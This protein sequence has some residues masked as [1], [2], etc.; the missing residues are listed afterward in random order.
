MSSLLVEEVRSGHELDVGKL[1]VFLAKTVPGLRLPLTLK[2][3][4]VGQSNPTY[5]VTDHEGQKYVLRKKPAGQLLSK[6]AHAVER[7]FRILQALGQHTQVPVPRVHVLCEDLNVVGTPF[8]LMEFLDGRILPDVRLPEIKAEERRQYWEALVDV[9]AL[10]H[11]VDYRRVGLGEGFGKSSGYYERQVKSLRRIS[12]AQAMAIGRNGDAADGKLPGIDR[13]LRWL[14]SRGCPDETTIVHGDFKMDNVVWHATEIRV[15]GILDWELS[16]LGNPRSDLANMLQPL[17]VPYT[18]TTGGLA[19]FSGLKGA[20][21]SEC[22]PNENML[23]A[24]YRQAMDHQQQ[25]QQQSPVLLEGW[26]YAKVFA[27][28]RNAVIQQGI[29]ARVA[30]GQASSSFAREVGEMFPNTMKMAMDIIDGL[31]RRGVRKSKL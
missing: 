26:D 3:F 14:D 13:L 12:E 11:K 21:V 25:Q 22:A 27:L 10:L 18:A 5:L 24:R 19:V 16:T 4:S 7:E 15:I 1:E 9:L 17:L 8:Y 6:T 20:P 30:K 23:L 31:D 2:Q 28:F 29:A